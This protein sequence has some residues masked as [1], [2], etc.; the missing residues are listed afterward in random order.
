MP[1]TLELSFAYLIYNV[2]MAFIGNLNDPKK[3]SGISIAFLF[4][5]MLCLAILVGTNYLIAT[6][7]SQ[8]RGTNNHKLVGHIF[9]K[10]RISIAILFIPM[11]F[12]LLFS[13]RTLLF[14]GMD[15][16]CS[17]HAGVYIRWS[18]PGVFFLSQ[19]DATRNYL[20]VMQKS[21]IMLY[22]TIIAAIVHTVICYLLV[23]K[24]EMGVKG[25]GIATSFTFFI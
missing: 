10:G 4:I 16:E 12:A 14:F 17:L 1:V 11:V 13:E 15:Y 2:N 21:S 19:F 5:N 22:A 3:V 8:A 6:L 24:L 9:N 25:A 18:I 20:N 7:G 23:F